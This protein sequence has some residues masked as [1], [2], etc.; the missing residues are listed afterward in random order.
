MASPSQEKETY[1]PH[2]LAYSTPSKSKTS[3]TTSPSTPD[4]Y[5]HKPTALHGGLTAS[6]MG[7]PAEP[8]RYS[9]NNN[10]NN[11]SNSNSNNKLQSAHSK[12]LAAQSSSSRNSNSNS[13]KLRK[14]DPHAYKIFLLLL[15]PQSKI[16]ELIQLLYNP[17]DTTIGSI[18]EM[19]PENATEQALGNQTYIGLCRPKTQ[20][21]LLN[22]DLLASEVRPGVDS[23]NITLG[24][25]LVAIP[26]GFNGKD[27]S[28]LSKQILANPKIV[29]LL[30]RAD[31]LSKKKRSSRS[32]GHRH[33]SS[34]RSS[35]KEHVHVLEKHIEEQEDSANIHSNESSMMQI[36]Q[37]MQHA[38]E[39]AAAA[40]AEIPNSHNLKLTR[41]NSIL[42]QG[43]YSQADSAC[44]I[45]DS[46][47]GD[48]SYTSWSK[49]FDA[50]FSAQSSICSGV[51]RRAHRR[52]QINVKRTKILKQSALAL[53][54]IMI[55]FYALDNHPHDQTLATIQATPMGI[56]GIFQCLFLLLVLYKM[57]RWVRRNND[58]A[59]PDQPPPQQRCPFLK[60]CHASMQRFKN[61]YAKKLSKQQHQHLKRT[62]IQ[63]KD[64]S[65]LSQRLRSF[66]LKAQQQQ[67]QQQRLNDTG[68][69]E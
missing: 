69:L 12:A 24:E 51:S 28:I 49:S 55:A 44:S 45:D 34:R 48:Q 62:T 59:S 64:D 67:Q 57:E 23:G 19:I 54:G 26:Q 11:N 58:Y 35:S 46:L 14:Q 21:E 6:P 30:K 40:N 17:N 5:V 39:A 52:K 63:E 66:S 56:M 10:G 25:I 2:A 3:A 38:A 36:Q 22:S 9:L 42:S 8:M 47:T 41:S 65:S 16:F 27:V 15:Q 13:S 53:F 20:E 7:A 43:D 33:R 60:A 68:S 32:R 50:S 1:L 31:P 29:K 61:R 18:L 37:A 4:V